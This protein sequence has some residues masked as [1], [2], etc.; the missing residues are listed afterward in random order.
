MPS[1]MHSATTPASAQL[2]API[3]RRTGRWRPSFIR[4]R[5]RR[6]GGI[7]GDFRRSWQTGCGRLVG[8]SDGCTSWMHWLLL[9]DRRQASK[10]RRFGL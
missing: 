10:P 8:M 6:Q 5:R 4:E 3:R 7:T 1:S 9:P 2:A